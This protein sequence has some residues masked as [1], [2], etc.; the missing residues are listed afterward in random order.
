M[1]PEAI[2]YTSNT[3]TT[4]QYAQLLG[5]ATGLPVYALA[6]A[7]KALAPG[8]RILYLGW[9]MAGQ[10]KGYKKAAKRY[11]VCA[12]CGVGMG[13]TGSQLE[14]VRRT[15]A[16]PAQTPVFT[17]QG[18]YDRARLHGVYKLMMTIMEKAAGKGLSEKENRTPEEDA[19]LE[20]M[21]HGG[22]RVSEENLEAVWEWY[23]MVS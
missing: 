5:Q 21:L 6:Q 18:G 19:M 13:T 9:L 7:G 10:V 20:L 16:V 1:K 4:A 12:V 17:L 14:D 11:T 8:S 22:S 23:Q 2:V 15:N 3:G